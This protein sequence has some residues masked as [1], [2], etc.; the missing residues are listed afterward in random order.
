MLFVY[1]WRMKKLLF[2][3]AIIYPISFCEAQN[4][5]CKNKNQSTISTSVHTLDSIYEWNCDLQT[6][7]YLFFRRTVPKID[8]LGVPL[9]DTLS[10]WNGSQWEYET[11]YSYD[12]DTS[13]NLIEFKFLT[14]DS[15][16]WENAMR[17]VYEYD[18][19]NNQTRF[20]KQLWD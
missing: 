16:Q 15:A 8:S 4:I 14:W 1:I 12:Y 17:F 11:I 3:S 6:D 2:I 5:S 18:G 9:D 7:Q 13:G 19:A 10:F 20:L